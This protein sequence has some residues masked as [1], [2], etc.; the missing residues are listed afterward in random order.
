MV[1][2]LPFAQDNIQFALVESSLIEQVAEAG[3]YEPPWLQLNSEY[4]IEKVFSELICAFAKPLQTLPLFSL[5]VP[6]PCPVLSK[7]KLS[8]ISSFVLAFKR[9]VI[10]FQLPLNIERSFCLK[11]SFVRDGSGVATVGPS[12]LEPCKPCFCGSAKSGKSVEQ[13]F[14]K[15]GVPINSNN[16]IN[17]HQPYRLQ[18]EGAWLAT[19][20]LPGVGMLK[21]LTSLVGGELTFALL[22]KEPFMASVT[23]A[24]AGVGM[25]GAPTAAAATMAALGMSSC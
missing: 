9:L 10:K 21:L 8:F 3:T 4:V 14:R 23:D 7:L 20:A 5:T 11:A 25:L 6:V 17:N 19:A 12:L 16:N 1:S 18:K 2:H 13:P 22:I 24:T 15:V